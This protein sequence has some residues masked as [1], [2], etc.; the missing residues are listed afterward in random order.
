MMKAQINGPRTT[1]NHALYR[2]E[3]QRSLEPSFTSLINAAAK[4]GWDRGE[5]AYAMLALA[6]DAYSAHAPADDPL[7]M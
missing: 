5:I 7:K 4:A 6:A 3:C 2:Q 1:W